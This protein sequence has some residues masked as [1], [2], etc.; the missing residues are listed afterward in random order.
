VEV[1]HGDEV[2]DISVAFS[3]SFD[4]LNFEVNPFDESR[5]YS[6]VEVM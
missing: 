4:F 3:E 5:G 2:S 6:G 1:N